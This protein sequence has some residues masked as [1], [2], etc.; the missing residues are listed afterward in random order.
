MDLQQLRYFLTVAQTNSV[1]GAARLLHM[2]QPPLSRQLRRM[3]EELGVA[4]FDRSGHRLHLTEAGRL[5]AQRAEEV[6]SLAER[7]LK[8]VRDTGLDAQ[9]L[10]CLGAVPSAASLWLPQLVAAFQQQ[11]PLVR[12]QLST[13]SSVAV[14]ELLLKGLIEVGIIHRPFEEQCLGWLNLPT[15]PLVAAGLEEEE[16]PLSLAQLAQRP[17]LLLRHHQKLLERHFQQAGLEPDLFCLADD[18][19]TLLAWAS[20][21]LGT[22][23]VPSKAV[24]AAQRS[25]LVCRSIAAPPLAAAPALIWAAERYQSQPAKAFISFCQKYFAPPS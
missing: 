13:G 3:E 21:G 6:L 19:L 16:E 9:G 24:A 8:E 20:A 2:A 4:L 7:S 25:G 18:S 14:R 15:E 5:L 1:T 12:F 11:R 10:L 17:L 23:L 22:A